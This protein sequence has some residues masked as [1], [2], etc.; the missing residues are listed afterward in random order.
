MAMSL[1]CVQVLPLNYYHVLYLRYNCAER[2]WIM[3]S[4]YAN[5]VGSLVNVISGTYIIM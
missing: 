3:W 5:I 1:E 4:K 2:N